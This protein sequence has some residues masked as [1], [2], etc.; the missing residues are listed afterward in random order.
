[1]VT[2]YFVDD[3]PAVL[4]LI[5]MVVEDAEDTPVSI[6]GELAGRT[7]AIQKVLATGIRSISVAAALIPELK[8]AI[9]KLNV[10]K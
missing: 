9:Q 4:R 1:M 7:E 8:W 6:C 2:E 3:H 10:G 5:E